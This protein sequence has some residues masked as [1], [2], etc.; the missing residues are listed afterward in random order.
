MTTKVIP[1][2]IREVGSLELHKIIQYN[3][4]YAGDTNLF[5]INPH[6]NTPIDIEIEY[7]H[8]DGRTFNIRWTKYSTDKTKYEILDD[9][10]NIVGHI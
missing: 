3:M 9:E 4:K 8:S 2:Y 7:A 1:L 5:S 10:F 6:S